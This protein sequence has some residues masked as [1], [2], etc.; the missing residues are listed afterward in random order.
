LLPYDRDTFLLVDTYTLSTIHGTAHDAA[1]CGPSCV[2]MA[3]DVNLVTIVRGF[4]DE[5]FINDFE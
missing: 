1:G 4:T 2:A 3:F 5:I